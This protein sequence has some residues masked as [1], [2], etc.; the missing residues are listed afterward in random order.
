MNLNEAYQ[1]FK[2]K[3][4]DVKLGLS[5]FCELR[6]NEYIT[7]GSKGTHSVCVCTY[8]QN[9]KLMLASFPLKDKKD[10]VAYT[11]E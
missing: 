8:H 10:N 2:E 5:K 11:L 1:L 3:H 7:V 9:F 4:P 6:P